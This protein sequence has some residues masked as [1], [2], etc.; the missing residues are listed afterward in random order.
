MAEKKRTLGNKI[1]LF[2][3][4]GLVPG[5]FLYLFSKGEQHLTPL[6]YL[7]PQKVVEGQKDPEYFQVPNFEMT[8][9]DGSTKTLDDFKDKYIISFVIGSS[10]PRDCEMQNDGFEQLLIKEFRNNSHYKD[11]AILVEYIDYNSSEKPDFKTLHTYYS[12]DNN[13]DNVHYFQCKTNEFFNYSAKEGE[14][15]M[16]NY[17]MAGVRSGSAYFK[18]IVLLDKDRHPRMIQLTDGSYGF[19]R[20]KD[21]LKVLKK[22]EDYAKRS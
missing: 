20:I 10:C 1:L 7:G 17:R 6:P 19:R 12:E 15:N 18:A 4:I 9:L 3:L 11:V 22:E 13:I 5:L 2:V 16:L 14:P 8:M 21:G